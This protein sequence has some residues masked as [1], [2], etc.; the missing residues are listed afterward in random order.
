MSQT[1]LRIEFR[2]NDVLTSATS[3]VLSDPTGTFGAK[4]TDTDAVVV[5]DGTPL[6]ETSTTGVYEYT[7]TDPAANLDYE[8]WAE[9]VWAG[10]TFRFEREAAGGGDEVDG[11]YADQ[12]DIEDIYGVENV[13]LWSNLENESGD[14]DA[15][16]IARALEYADRW[17]DRELRVAGYSVAADPNVIPTT[18]DDFD[19]L[20]DVAAEAAG[21]WLYKSRGKQDQDA[22]MAGKMAGHERHAEDAL[23]DLIMRGIDG[24]RRRSSDNTIPTGIGIAGSPGLTIVRGPIRLPILW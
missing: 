6:V 3:A 23:R 9:I 5:A 16:R 17:I 18:S 15:T 19:H 8:W 21:A 4:R 13:R 12:A 14:A 1:T 2:V 24:T 7:F 22:N 11:Y 20:T 10:Q